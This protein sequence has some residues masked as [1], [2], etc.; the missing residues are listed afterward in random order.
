MSAKSKS[1]DAPVPK[2]VKGWIKIVSLIARLAASIAQSFK[3]S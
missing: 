2:E 3:A 1:A